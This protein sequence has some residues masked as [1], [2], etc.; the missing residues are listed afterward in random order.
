[1]KHPRTAAEPVRAPYEDDEDEG[2]IYIPVPRVYERTERGERMYDLYSRLLLDRIIL[3]NRE[4]DDRLANVVTAQLLFLESQDPEKPINIYIN[5]PGGVI[6]SGLAIYDTMQLVK[7]VVSTTVIGQAAS[8]GAAILLAGAKGHRHALPNARIMIHQP[9]GGSRGV[10]VDIEIQTREMIRVR[11]R[12]YEIMAFHTGRS[13]EE[14]TKAC[15]RDNFMSPEE[16][17]DFGLIDHVV[18]SKKQMAALDAANKN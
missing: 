5:S 1:M 8:M 16:A 17:R 2:V 11:E 18:E 12:L 3:I 4:F 6:T 14:I 9:S 15:M 13:V 10:S 7:P